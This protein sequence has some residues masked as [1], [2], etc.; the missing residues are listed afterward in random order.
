MAK[1]F[2]VPRIKNVEGLDQCGDPS[3]GNKQP[4]SNLDSSYN[5]QIYRT[6]TSLYVSWV[7]GKEIRPTRKLSSDE[8]KALGVQSKF[9]EF[10]MLLKQ[11]TSIDNVDTTGETEDESE[12][13]ASGH[14]RNGIMGRCV[15]FR[16]W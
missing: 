5:A 6:I 11:L 7:F 10:R 16:R 14:G 9:K 8:I 12:P 3:P 2:N 13:G 4:I 15:L 1:Q